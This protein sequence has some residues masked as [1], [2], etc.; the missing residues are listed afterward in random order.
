M[1]DNPQARQKGLGGRL[2]LAS[3]SGVLFVF[4]KPDQYRFW[5]KGMNFP[6]DFIWVRDGTVVELLP[7]VS[8]PQPGMRDEM[9]PVFGPSVE[10][11]QVLE[12]NSGFIN[13]NNIKIGD[14]VELLK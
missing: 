14:K 9:L 6:L 11:D 2:S 3:D 12:V 5:M 13:S 10:I 1:A 7:N 4:D 8:S